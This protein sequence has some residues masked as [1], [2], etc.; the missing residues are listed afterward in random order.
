[1]LVNWKL[2]SDV[3]DYVKKHLKILVLKKLPGLI[4]EKNL[5]MSA[6][7]QK[8]RLKGAAKTQIRLILENH[9]FILKIQKQDSLVT[10]RN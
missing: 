8:R 2:R 5:L 9:I 4:I 7:P 3:N 6:Y 10:Y 1:M